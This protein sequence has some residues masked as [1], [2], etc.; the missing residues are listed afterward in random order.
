MSPTKPSAV[1]AP[2]I[3]SLPLMI[4]GLAEGSRV[5]Y[6]MGRQGRAGA[7]GFLPWRNCGGIA[8]SRLPGA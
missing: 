3:A 7:L 8:P 5:L 6:D 2:L 1:I 4:T